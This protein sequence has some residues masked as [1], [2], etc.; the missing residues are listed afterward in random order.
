MYRTPAY[1]VQPMSGQPVRVKKKRGCLTALII[2][3]ILLGAAVAAVY[4]LLPGM[5]RPYDLGIKSTEEAYESTLHKLQLSKDDA[6]ASG[7]ADDYTIVYGG[8]QSIQTELDSEELTSFFNENRPDYY[9][10]QDVQIRINE[11]DTVEVS[12]NIDTNYIFSEVLG[13]AY[14]RK[15]AEDALPMLGLLPD[16]INVYFDFTGGV[17]NNVISDLDIAKISVLG[18]P[19]PESLYD[20]A[21]AQSFIENTLNAYIAEV[22]AEHGSSY[23]LLDFQDGALVFEG[24][25]PSSVTHVPAP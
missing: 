8:A 23:D 25:N 1:Q 15:D 22:R 18:I 13:G 6:P 19:L 4:F 10:L 11:D 21:S 20:S 7:N 9:A 5:L 14:S 17:R 3:V 24:S 16:K 2:A 12:A